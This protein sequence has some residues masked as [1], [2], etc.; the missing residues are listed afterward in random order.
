MMFAL[1]ILVLSH[2]LT[3]VLIDYLWFLKTQV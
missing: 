1:E 3:V 2:Q